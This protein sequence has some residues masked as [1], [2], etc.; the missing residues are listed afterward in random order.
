[1]NFQA[2]LQ[3]AYVHEAVSVALNNSFNKGKR[4]SYSTKP[5]ALTKEDEQREVQRKQKELEMRIRNRISEMQKIKGNTESTSTK[6]SEVVKN[7]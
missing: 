4:A 7:G 1:M 5:Y 2:W 6:G 3:G